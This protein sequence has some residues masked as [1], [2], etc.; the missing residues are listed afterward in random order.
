MINTIITAISQIADTVTT[1]KWGPLLYKNL[2]DTN[3]DYGT[4]V[5]GM[6]AAKAGYGSSIWDKRYPFYPGMDLEHYRAVERNDFLLHLFLYLLIAAAV[7]VGTILLVKA[8]KRYK[9]KKAIEKKEKE[10]AKE[11]L[12]KITVSRRSDNTESEDSGQ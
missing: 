10:P 8:I 5:L 1:K 7:V 11:L 6:E 4:N 9:A 12:I 3:S 2:T